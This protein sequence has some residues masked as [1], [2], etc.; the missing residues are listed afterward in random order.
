MFQQKSF[1]SP[2]LDRAWAYMPEGIRKTVSSEPIIPV[3]AARAKIIAGQNPDFIRSD[4]GQVIGIFPEKEVYYGPSS[5]LEELRQLV[6]R[7]WTHAYKLEKKQGVPPAGLDKKHVA[8]VSGA[9]E[10]LS[11][12]MHLLAYQQ[13]IGLMPLHWSNYK[14]IILNAG[15]NPVVLD[16][17]DK[18]YN[19]DFVRL[20]EEIDKNSI[21]SLLLNF[22]NNPSGD[23]LTDGELG[24]LAELARRKNL[25]LISDEVY[26]FIRYKGQPQSMLSFAPER[27][28]VVSSAS[29]EYLI[30]GAR[31]GYVI[32]AEEEFTSSWM[33]KMIRS[34][35]SSPNTL[36]QDKLINILKEEIQDFENGTPPRFI[37]HIKEEIRERCALII[38]VLQD[39]GFSLAGR[40]KDFPSGAISVL[41]R[42]PEDLKVDDVAFVEKALEMG[43]FSAV[44]ASV[45]GAPNCIRFGYAGMPQE[46]IKKL[47][48]NLQDVLD[49]FRR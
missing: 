19:P 34:F 14:G 25:V 44:P 22:P 13:N 8:I 23:I 4:Q 45:F 9:T 39:K 16:L 30:P 18:D 36:G 49:F 7:F 31:V 40:D 1:T 26:N 28:V 15:G 17:F 46:T 2:L 24:K 32:A 29:K 35:S 43:K 5:G 37:T 33:P 6:G 3:I 21:T 20:E 11:I 42:L 47:S 48:Q 12:V 38:A 41:A 10:G 27:T